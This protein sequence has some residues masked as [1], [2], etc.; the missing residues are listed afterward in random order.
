MQVTDAHQAI[1]DGA[2]AY[3]EALPAAQRK[4]L[5]QYFTGLP[6]GKLLA[7]LAWQPDTRTVLDPMAGHGDLLDAAWEAAAERVANLERLDGIEFDTKTATTCALRLT[8]IVGNQHA[9]RRIIAGDAFNPASVRELPHRAYDLVITNPPYVRYQARQGTGVDPVRTGLCELVSAHVCGA[10]Q[11]VWRTLAESYSGLA[12]LSVPALLL[13]ASLV[14][15]DGRLALV[16]PATWRSRDYADV[17]RY[18]LLRCFAIECIVEDTQPGWFSDALVRT[19]LIVAR[20]L[21]ADEIARPVRS[22]SDWPAAMWLQVAPQAAREDSLVGTAFD[23]DAPEAALAAWVRDGCQTPKA[24]INVRA[25]VLR[26]EWDLLASRIKRRRWYKQLEG[27]ADHLP[28]FGMPQAEAST[29]IPESLRDILSK[30]ILAGSLSTLRD[31]GIE[32]GQGLRTGCNGFFYVTACGPPDGETV[33]VEAS[34]LFDNCRVAVP[35]DAIRPV[36]RRQ[37]ELDAG[38]GQRLPNGRVLDLHGWIL[39]E[40][41]AVVDR[42]KAAYVASGEEIPRVMPDG[43]AAFV[44]RAAATA[45][46]GEGGGALIPTLS[47]VRT[48]IRLP[49]RDHVTPRFWYMLPEFAPRH[50][51]AAFAPRINHGVAWVESNLDPAILIDANFA[52]FWAPQGGW[53]RHA[54]KAL[55][56]SAWCRAFMEALGTPFGGGALKLEATHLRHLPIPVLSASARQELDAAGKRL[57]REATDVQSYIDKI[58]FDALLSRASSRGIG[59]RLACAMTERARNMSCARQRAA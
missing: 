48:N 1:R 11:A 40:D 3:E 43:L 59:P 12:D 2:R 32:V 19:H 56:D 5:G 30:D 38:F 36:L 35:V 31:A 26:D 7:H 18:L 6:L 37:A 20:R 10:P 55:L 47:A 33:C 41:A 39:P 28:L 50:V 53:S 24:G 22:R 52:T 34:A 17:I 9:D 51:P 4:R 44:R 58:I 29:V 21:T 25:F 16:I 15:P 14:R 57:T 49:K 13:A 23:D 8:A 54:L 42:A 27:D 45:L 46:K